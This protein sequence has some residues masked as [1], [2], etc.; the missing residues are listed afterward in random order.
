MPG[1][2]EPPTLATILRS[3]HQTIRAIV[4]QQ[5]SVV[6]NLDGV[7]VMVTGRIPGSDPSSYGI[8]FV[9]PTS[10]VPVAFF[11]EDGTLGPGLFFYGTTGQ[12]VRQQDQSGDTWFNSAGYVIRKSD[13]TGDYWYDGTSAQNLVLS[14]T[15]S[16]GMRVY[17][18]TAAERVTLGPLSN[19]D[20]G[21]ECFD[22]S[23]NGVEVLPQY[24]VFGAGP[25]T[26]STSGTAALGLSFSAPVGGSGKCYVALQALLISTATNGV[27]SELILYVDGTSTALNI[28]SYDN[29]STT[30]VAQI[31]LSGRVLLT[32]LTS[33]NHTFAVYGTSSFGCN[34]ENVSIQVQPV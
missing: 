22:S 26:I 28:Q 16:G 5:Q 29:N 4:S 10:H 11:G 21:L 19:G 12:L 31:T 34:A 2:W 30:G 17:D 7:P 9:D 6:S 32:G 15:P 20:Y 33:G 27:N 1:T 8:Q 14:I 18:T 13:A 23:G 24:D 25:Y 3:H